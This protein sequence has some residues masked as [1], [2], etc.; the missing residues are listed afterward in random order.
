MDEMLVDVAFGFDGPLSSS[1]S[2]V[3]WIPVEIAQR[4][5]RNFLQHPGAFVRVR[6]SD[7]AGGAWT[8]YRRRK[9]AQV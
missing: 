7:E 1:P 5:A 9:H 2:V 6:A 3:K 4:N 8:T